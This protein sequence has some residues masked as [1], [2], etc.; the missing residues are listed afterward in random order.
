MYTKCRNNSSSTRWKDWGPSKTWGSLSGLEGS[1]GTENCTVVAFFTT[2]FASAW[3]LGS[4]FSNFEMGSWRLSREVWGRGF[5]KYG[6]VPLNPEPGWKCKVWSEPDLEWTTTRVRS[7]STVSPPTLATS[8]TS[9]VRIACA[10][11]ATCEL[12]E[13]DSFLKPGKSLSGVTTHFL[14]PHS[15]TMSKPPSLS[16]TSGLWV[17][18]N[19]QNVETYRKLMGACFR[20][21][22]SLLIIR[23]WRLSKRKWMGCLLVR[24]DILT[25]SYVVSDL[26]GWREK[27]VAGLRFR[28]SSLLVR[29]SFFFSSS[30]SRSSSFAT[31]LWTA[32]W[33][34]CF[35]DH[36]D[37]WTENN[38]RK[39]EWINRRST[40]FH[41]RI[42]RDI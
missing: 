4:G 34:L 16:I 1:G 22:L 20:W 28:N 42:R 31:S 19:H 18:Y 21:S 3:A 17:C 37:F 7:L 33:R 26:G 2:S 25:L 11:G 12:P 41:M 29:S 13:Y 8:T 30:F 40:T 32:F 38:Q 14:N 24:S 6:R 39:Q 15:Q 35:K 27:W 23:M 9:F 36:C 10:R 5:L